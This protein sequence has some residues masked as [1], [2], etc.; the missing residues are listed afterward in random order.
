MNIKKLEIL[1]VFLIILFIALFGMYYKT[2]CDKNA[3]RLYKQGMELYKEQ[4][5]SDAYY[6]FKQIKSVSNMYEIALL[7]QYQCAYNLNDKKTTHIKLKELIKTTKNEYIRPWALYQEA[8]LSQEMNLDSKTISNKKFNYIHL[9]YPNTDFGTA[10]AYK[11][12]QTLK[13]KNPSIAK[14]NFISYLSYAKGGKFSLSAT[15]ELLK[16]NVTL[17][18]E[19][20][21]VIGAS[22]LANKH[23]QKA[24]ECYLKTTFSKNWYNISK[25]YLG[26]N[27]KTQEK[28]VI[29]KGLNLALSN[30]DEKDISRS[31]DRLASLSNIN[32]LELLQELY[33]K[34]QNSYAFATITYKLAE[35]SGTLRAIKLYETIAND[36][37]ASIWAS[38]SLWEVFWYNWEQHRFETCEKLAKKHI[39]QYSNFQDCPRIAYWYARTLLKTRKNAQAREAFYDVINK[40]PLSY[41]SFL[42][43]KQLKKSKAKKIIVKK[44][45]V[46]Y[47]RNSLDKL[48]FKDK[49]LLKIA[50]MNDWE[51]IDSFKI[52]DEYIKSWVAFKKDNPSLAINLAKNELFKEKETDDNYDNTTLDNEDTVQFS[53]QMLKMVYPIFYEN[54][55]NQYAIHFKQSPYLFLSLIREESHFNKNAKSSVGAIGLTQLMQSTANFIEKDTISKETLLN[56]KDNIRIGLNYFNYLVNLFNGNEYLAI[57]AYNAGPGNIKKWLS[58]SNIVSDE[59]EVFVENIP[60]LETKNYIKKILSSYWVYLNIYSAKNK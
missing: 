22:L 32:K 45:I 19:D 8:V 24:L 58:D 57:L 50:Q 60:Y 53:N 42:S 31:I 20:Y 10:S 17:S 49:T 27:D 34:H 29:L 30:V 5:Y 40:Y 28:Q 39:A 38:N 21:E 36:Y 15:D 11:T 43:V 1:L 56:P 33:S 2:N 48:I 54:E 3:Q 47:N 41:Y 13:E 6:N 52:D 35:I 51:L 44:P 16:L 26:L 25:C 9:H 37:P 14:E 23:Y 18:K 4:K 55:I 46:P 12:A 59:I 7:K